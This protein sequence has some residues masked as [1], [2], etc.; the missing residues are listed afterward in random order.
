[1]TQLSDRILDE[2]QNDSDNGASCYNAGSKGFLIA[3]K[4]PKPKALFVFEFLTSE[5]EK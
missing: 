3:Y 5:K 4:S 1:M 2:N